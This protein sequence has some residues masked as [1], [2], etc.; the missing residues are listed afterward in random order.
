M[1]RGY[2]TRKLEVYKLHARTEPGAV[3]YRAFFQFLRSLSA[4]DR[5]REL[6]GKLIAVPTFSL[7]ESKVWLIAYEGT[8]GLNPL[9]FDATQA[10]ERIQR[11]RSGE[12]VAHKTHV[13]IDLSSRDAVIEYNHAGAKAGDI[14][15]LIQEIA[16]PNPT[17]SSLIV[18]LNPVVDEQFLEAIDRFG[19]IRLASLRV[20]RPNIDWTDHYSNAHTAEVILTASRGG[21]LSKT[22]GLVR[23]I[24]ELVTESIAILKSAKLTGV[25]SGETAETTISLANHIEHQK[26]NVRVTSDGHVDDEDIK[27]KME[28]FLRSRRNR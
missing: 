6:G 11:L 9:I 14:A 17:Y 22:Q 24:K 3:D 27:S 26:V 5:A 8:I 28:S 20:S 7:R 19:R 18:D 13:L 12:I 10:R 25:R 2:T 23:F 15:W 21:T 4:E 1:P 16:S